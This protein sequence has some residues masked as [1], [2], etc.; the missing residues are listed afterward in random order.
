MFRDYKKLEN[1]LKTEQAKKKALQVKK[2]ELEKKKMEINK[3]D[4]NDTINNLIQEKDIEIQN[5][6]KNLKLPHEG[7]V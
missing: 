4:G 5:L 6:K 1:K 2:T 7:H 3:E